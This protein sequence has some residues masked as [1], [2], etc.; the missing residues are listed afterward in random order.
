M[1]W[2]LAAVLQ[3]SRF[4]ILQWLCSAVYEKY[5]YDNQRVRFLPV[6]VYERYVKIVCYLCVLNKETKAFSRV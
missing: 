3:N 1:P 5:V 4:G 2:T 6:K